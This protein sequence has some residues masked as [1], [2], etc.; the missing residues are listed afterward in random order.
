VE[1]AVEVGIG[2]RLVAGV[3]DRPRTGRGT[4]DAL[5]DVVGALTD[6]IDRAARSLQDLPRTGDDLPRD[7]ERDE[8]LGQGQEVGGALHEVVLMAAVGVTGGVGVVLEQVDV[9][10]D[11]LFTQPTLGIHA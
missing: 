1:S 7:Q 3:D 8:A 9:P 10:G 2:V 6:A 11:A 4:R 5:P